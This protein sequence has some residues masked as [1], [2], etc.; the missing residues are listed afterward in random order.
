MTRQ[1]KEGNL[2]VAEISPTAATVGNPLYGPSG[3]MTYRV[4]LQ[5]AMGGLVPIDV[6]AETGDEAATKALAQM[7]GSKV[8]NVNP[9]PQKKAE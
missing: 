8:T 9:A 5:T 7:P 4:L 3:S 6:D 1:V 2:H